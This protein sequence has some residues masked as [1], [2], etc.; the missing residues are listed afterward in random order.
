MNKVIKDFKEDLFKKQLQSADSKI[1]YLEESYHQIKKENSKMKGNNGS[2]EALRAEVHNCHQIIDRLQ[3]QN[4][5]LLRDHQ[6][7]EFNID[8]KTSQND[9]K[10]STIN[11]QK[12]HYEHQLRHAHHAH[13]ELQ[14]K[15]HFLE[16][17]VSELKTILLANEDKLHA[18]ESALEEA[19]KKNESLKLYY[20]YELETYKKKLY[21][22]EREA[23][24]GRQRSR[25][26]HHELEV[27][28][29]ETHLKSESILNLE[30]IVSELIRKNSLLADPTL[31]SHDHSADIEA[32]RQLIDLQQQLIFA[33][34]EKIQ[35]EVDLKALDHRLALAARDNDKYKLDHA[36]L[37]SELALV[38]AALAKAGTEVDELRYQ[39]RREQTE[40]ARVQAQLKEAA[41]QKEAVI[42]ELRTEA[43]RGRQEEKSLR[44]KLRDLEMK[45][46]EEEGVWEATRVRLQEKEER[47]AHLERLVGEHLKQSKALS[48]EVGEL[49]RQNHEVAKDRQRQLKKNEELRKELDEAKLHYASYQKAIN[50]NIADSN[51]LRK[52][53]NRL[54][55]AEER[56]SIRYEELANLLNIIR[57]EKELIEADKIALQRD[58]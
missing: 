32:K 48:L 31:G 6:E 34:N 37:T 51:A 38:Q 58:N 8:K 13:Q 5:K 45:N 20:E 39:L 50:D 23:E 49:E 42:G 10:V 21:E 57:R 41:A 52:E 36:H 24:E 11:A 43:E 14:K 35:L 47:I 55:D 1:N 18:R 19:L 7:Q 4:A 17:E 54:T 30:K 3:K 15:T 22:L 2:K 46:S 28:R 16:K 44:A 29:K 56:T 27:L 40:T 26:S 12:E 9:R 53:I 25:D 33:Q